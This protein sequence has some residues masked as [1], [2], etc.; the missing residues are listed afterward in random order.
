MS[1]MSKGRKSRELQIPKEI[2][3]AHPSSY[4]AA[5]DLEKKLDVFGKDVV[6][7]MT[8]GSMPDLLEMSWD[9][10]RDFKEGKVSELTGTDEELAEYFKFKKKDLVIKL[11]GFMDLASNSLLDET[12]FKNSNLRD[13]TASLKIV[14]DMLQ[15]LHGTKMQKEV[16]H[17]HVH[18]VGTIVEVDA[19]LKQTRE[20]IDAIEAEYTDV[21]PNED[22]NF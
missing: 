9:M 19:K 8:Y 3:D 13:L 6:E 16:T 17:T 10:F 1:N 2:V 18:T 20:E 5:K 22:T 11:L 12:K 7:L 15:A 21:E 14:M 4:V